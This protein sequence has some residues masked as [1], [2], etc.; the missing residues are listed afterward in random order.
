M[1]CRVE[2]NLIV[3][4]KNSFG[5][6][7]DWRDLGFWVADVARLNPEIRNSRFDLKKI[8]SGFDQGVMSQA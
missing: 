7:P 1:N 5:V 4:V 6:E 3:S 2:P 8:I